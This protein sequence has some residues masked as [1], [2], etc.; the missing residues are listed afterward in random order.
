MDDFLPKP[1]DQ[2]QLIAC[3]K[4]WLKQEYVQMSEPTSQASVHGSLCIIDRSR[5]K[6]L[7]RDMG[8]DFAELIPAF[9]SSIESLL[10]ELESALESDDRI[11]VKRCFHSLKS[12]ADNLGARR[13][14][15]TARDGE[16][17]SDIATGPDLSTLKK[18][19]TEEY[20]KAK[21]ELANVADSG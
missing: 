16:K 1:I 8:E 20:L 3:L 19:L 14:H 9:I 18:Q 7:Q 4:K 17:L 10:Q 11:T 2:A 5:I 21:T 12:A 15:S 13:L 6:T